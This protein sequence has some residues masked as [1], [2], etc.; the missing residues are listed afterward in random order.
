MKVK[1]IAL[2]AVLAVAVTVVFFSA[3]TAQVPPT[4]PLVGAAAPG[5][6]IAVCNIA[7]VFVKY[8]RAN[9][10][11]KMLEL[12]RAELEVEDKKRQN[13]IN[14]ARAQLQESL[15]PG[16]APYEVKLLQVERMAIERQVWAKVEQSKLVRSHRKLT[17]EMY[18]AILAKIERIALERGFYMVLYRDE[19]NLASNSTEQ[20]LAKIAQRKVLYHRPKSDITAEVTRLLNEQ[21]KP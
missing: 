17:E 21:Y 19:L 11:T 8:T 7:E 2:L 6:P 13:A 10:L 16:S 4:K 5:G 3:V 14:V 9:D 18:R 20:L 1:R 12:K 15:T